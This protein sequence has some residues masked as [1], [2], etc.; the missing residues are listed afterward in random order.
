[1]K[2]VHKFILVLTA[3]LLIALA[4]PQDAY[5][6]PIMD[7]RTVLGESYTLE[8]G[9]ILDGDLN[10]IGGVVEIQEGATVGGDVLV[11]GGLVTIN[12]TVEG[13]V[14]AIGGTVDV[15]S[16]AIIQGDL[17]SPASYINVDPDA[18]VMGK[19][20]QGW[21]SLWTGFETPFFYRPRLIRTPGIRIV[22]VL[23][24]VGRQTAF[25]LVLVALGA[26]LLLIMPNATESMTK[27]LI[28]K[29]WSI[30][31]Y[32]A[33]T[34]LALLIGVILLSITICLIPL[35]L[36]IGLTFG[37][38]LLVGWL[39]L[40]YE[41]GKR[42]ATSI[43]KTKWHPVLSAALGNMVLY[44]IAKGLELIPCLGGFLVF[45]TMLFALGMVVVTL[46]GTNPYPRQDHG[47][48]DGKLI[49]IQDQPA[50][51]PDPITTKKV[52]E[53]DEDKIISKPIADEKPT[54]DH[55]IEALGLGTRVDNV[56]KDAGLST[57]EAVLKRL[58]SGDQAL[59][60]INGFGKKSLSDLKRALQHQ[61]FQ[62]P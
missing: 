43:F 48:D 4:F 12:G 42:I 60:D 35:A 25:T 41:L 29:P 21:Q 8:S 18:V 55:P 31:G 15:T 1:M 49:L 7:G 10:V 33:L 30:L 54:Q 62:V 13:N 9:K 37:L 53:E 44:L 51:Q 39:T 58:K 2:N 52:I 27:A 34:A 11:I 57:I 36:L 59:L 47:I 5:A 46:F 14:Y 6:A 45:I 50:D 56:L 38:A 3:M 16:T 20:H 61:G 19:Q 26:L 40:G 24:T 22:T 32:G 28:T 17:L 23:N